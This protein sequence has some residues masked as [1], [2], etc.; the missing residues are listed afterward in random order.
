MCVYMSMK[1]LGTS[2]SCCTE[3][4]LSGLK[5]P[6]TNSKSVLS[7]GKHLTR[8]D[9]LLASSCSVKE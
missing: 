2:F 6:L 4:T 3:S 9:M 5:S 1:F 7:L 8:T